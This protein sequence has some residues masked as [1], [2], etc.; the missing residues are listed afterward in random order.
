MR[1]MT[2]RPQTL[3]EEIANSVSHGVAL[4]AAIAAAPILID[5][6]RLLGAANVVGAVVFAA[7]MVLLYLTSTLYHA[8]PPG[9]AKRVFM[10]LDHGAIYLFIAGS[11]TPFALGVLGGPWGWTLFG[12]VWSIAAVGVTLKAFDRLSHPWLSTGL[13]L[14]MGWLALIAAAPLVE[15]MAQP[16]LALLLAGGLAY[17]VGVVFFML[18]SRL[19][20]AH[21]VWH[22][23]VAAGTGFHFF[24]VLNYAA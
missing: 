9:R 23:F 11:Y 19:R 20:Y 1:A 3:G 10:K 7:T 13:Y 22:G 15:R 14:V 4:L 2:E 8:L 12:V 21:T 17:T 24:A 5:A 16:G 18:D 6:T